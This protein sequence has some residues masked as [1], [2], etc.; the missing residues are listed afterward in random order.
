MPHIQI[1][2]NPRMDLECRNT[3]QASRSL[4]DAGNIADLNRDGIVDSED[5]CMM[6]DYWH[7]DEP[8]CDIAP[9]PFGDGIVDIQDMAILGENLFDDY[10][11]DLAVITM[12]AYWG[13]NEATGAIA[14]DS[15]NNHNGTLHGDPIWQPNN[16]Q[17]AGALEFDGV[18]DYITTDFILNPANGPFSVFA[19]INGGAPG[20]TIISQTDGTDWLSTD[21]SD[22]SLITVLK[23]LGR[24][25][26]DLI[27]HTIITD[28]NWHRIGLV[29]DGL[30]RALYVDDILVAEDTQNSLKDSDNGLYIGC[31]KNMEA[32][33]FWSGLIDDVRIY[34]RVVIP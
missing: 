8:Y 3:L 16:G 7:T 5:V 28:G 10:R 19:W 24:G 18:D 23:G 21:P 34:N 17:V 31:G 27:S 14:Y 20:Q 32:G 15:V 9:A 12:I 30:N 29:W 11:Q 1:R 26:A 33:T 25:A 4:S 6:V 2:R 13:L 22:G